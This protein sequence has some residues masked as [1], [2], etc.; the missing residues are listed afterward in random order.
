LY[1]IYTILHAA[2]PPHN[3]LR[4][5]LFSAFSEADLCALARGCG[6]V[7]RALRKFD[8]PGFVLSSMILALQQACSLRQQAILAG[9][10]TATTISKQALHKRLARPAALFLQGC[11]AA[12]IGFKLAGKLACRPAAFGR[13]LLQDSTC[14][15]LPAALASL[16]PGPANQS[17]K[18]QACLRI[19]CLYDLLTERFVSF[20]LSPFTRNDQAAASDLLPLLQPRDMVLR[21]LG[22]FTLDSLKTIAAKGA[23][24]LSRLRYGPTLFCPKTARPIDLSTIL[25]P[26]ATLDAEFLLGQREKLPLRLLAFALPPKIA[27]ERRRKARA[28]RDKRLSHS[29]HYLHLLGWNIFVTNAS[30]DQLPLAIAAKLYRL[31]WRVEILFKAWKSHLGLHHVSKLGKHQV[32]ALVYGLLLFAVLMHHH[33]PLADE[34]TEDRASPHRPPPLSLLRLAQFFGS[35]LLPLLL[36]QLHPDHFLQRLRE[37]IYAHC[38]YERRRRKN[39]ADLRSEILS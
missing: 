16:F 21:D 2:S 23:F 26:G 20:A 24:F 34:P 32:E 31:R 39:Y 37:Q 27:E 1:S 25:R 17:A 29:E 35:W 14:I 30:Q 5:T 4:Q 19:Q 8:L 28:N 38:R 15:A 9:I 18:P 6:F 36:A 3:P 12:A 33:T 13:I 7:R 10:F 11:L 22:Y